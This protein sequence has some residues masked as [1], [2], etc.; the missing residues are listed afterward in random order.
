MKT[1]VENE[2]FISALRSS[3][4]GEKIVSDAEAARLARRRE[5]LKKKTALGETEAEF[6]DKLRAAEAKTFDKRKAYEAAALALREIGAKIYMAQQLVE[7]LSADRQR[8]EAEAR[9]AVM[10]ESNPRRHE[11]LWSPL[12]GAIKAS[13]TAVISSKSEYFDNKYS[14][15]GLPVPKET[16]TS[17]PSV[18][19]RIAFIQR[20]INLAEELIF[21][22]D[23]T[24][25][26]LILIRESILAAAPASDRLVN[27]PL[28]WG[29]LEK[30][31]DREIALAVAA[32]DKLAEQCFGLATKEDARHD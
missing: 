13:R 22:I 6:L 21:R 1:T 7:T 26:A 9:S 28:V 24:D 29:A 4:L 15:S 11:L 10:R 32:A 8:E 25:D 3:P 27:V 19:A 23:D 12:Y 5:A 30:V 2:N 16:F 20:A 14:F 31:K 17:A 18:M